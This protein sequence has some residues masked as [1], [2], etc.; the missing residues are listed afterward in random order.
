[1][2]EVDALAAL[3]ARLRTRLG[4][5]SAAEYFSWSSGL[6][7]AGAVRQQAYRLKM[8]EMLEAQPN[9]KIKQAEVTGLILDEEPLAPPAASPSAMGAMS[10]LVQSSS[11]LEH[12]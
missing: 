10:L 4:F 3:W 5:S 11:L 6:V 8:R 12:S 9:L 2:R 7:A 1:V